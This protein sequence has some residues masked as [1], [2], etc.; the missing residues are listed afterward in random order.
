MTDQKGV[1]TMPPRDENDE[2]RTPLR[3]D[4]V[5][6]FTWVLEHNGITHRDLAERMGWRNH[7]RIYNWLNLKV[8]PYPW[9]VFAIERAI[10]TP[11]GTLSRTLGYLPPEARASAGAAVSFDEALDAHPFL[12]PAAK[13]IIRTVVAEFTPAEAKQPRRRR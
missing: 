8:E 1:V 13:R 4:F 11:P 12:T 7:T 2:D 3:E 5:R 9:Q 6:T 10:P